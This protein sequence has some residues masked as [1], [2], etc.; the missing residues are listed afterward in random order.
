MITKLRQLNPAV[1]RALLVLTMLAAQAWLYW[2]GDN[3]T[4]T[5]MWDLNN[6]YGPWVQQMASTH[7]ILGLQESWIYPYIDV[8]PLLLAALLSPNNYQLGWVVM[9][10]I[11]NLVALLALLGWRQRPGGSAI[12]AGWFWV[13]AL[14]LLGPVS[15]SRLDSVSVALAVLAVAFL[16]RSKQSTAAALMAVATWVKIWPAA[17]FFGALADAANR[18]RI[19]WVGALTGFGLLVFGLLVGKP[20]YLLSFAFGQASRGIQIEAPAASPWLWW[21][22]SDPSAAGI[23]FS[24]ELLTFQVFGPAA[25]MVAKLMDLAML[26]ALAITAWLAYAASR[27]PDAS[28]QSAITWAFFTAT[29]DLIFFNKVGSPQYYA[30]L[31]VPVILALIWKVPGRTKLAVLVLAALLLT[32]LVF[33]VFYDQLLHQKVFATGLLTIRNLL[34]LGLLVLG[35]LRLSA[36][37]KRAQTASN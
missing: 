17:F 31:I 18:K 33:P 16:V 15:I 11:L 2:L 10:G 28:W 13:I 30:W 22:I 6:V 32:G 37:S 25:A 23:L 29:T 7:R 35:N 1:H 20:S 27:N 26:V 3:G 9:V 24:R 36:L 21:G 4:G 19:L 14:V 34:L 5:P 12:A 8:I